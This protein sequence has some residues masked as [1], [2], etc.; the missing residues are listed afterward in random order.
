MSG[1]TLLV[2]DSAPQTAERAASALVGTGL[3]VRAA[4]DADEAEKAL[5]SDD[6]VAVLASVRFPRGNGYD[7]ARQVRLRRPEAAVFLLCG[8]FDVYNAERAA[9][10]GV[11]ARVNRP[12]SPDSLRAQIEAALGAFPNADLASIESFEALTEVDPAPMEAPTPA[13]RPVVESLAD[14]GS[15]P[16]SSDERIATFLPRDWRSLP[17]VKVDPTVVAPAMEKAIL[18]VLPEVVDVVLNKAIA[19]SPAFREMLEVAV[20][21]AV[22]EAL[23]LLARRVVLERLAELEAAAKDPSQG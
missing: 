6:V 15:P 23:P 14:A 22:R 13:P 10:A 4:H 11:S 2:V 8:G 20:E 17:P 7:L 21:Q 3:V 12:F 18:A 5:S 1:P 19:T 9:E 16:P